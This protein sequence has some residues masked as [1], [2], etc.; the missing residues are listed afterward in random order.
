MRNYSYRILEV[1]NER[2]VIQDDCFPHHRSITNAA[3]EVVEEIFRFYGNIDIYYYDSN[4]DLD[5]LS[6]TNGIFEGFLPT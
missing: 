4:G 2:V 1:N 5:R 6:H 3:E